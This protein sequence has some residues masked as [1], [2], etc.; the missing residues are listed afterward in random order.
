MSELTKPVIL[1]VDDEPTNLKF[2]MEILKEDY[3]V[4]L[5][6]SGERALVFL[7][8]R[9]PDI[10][11]LD[12]EMPKMNGYEVIQ[13][14]KES[15]DWADI[16]IIFLTGLEGRDKEQEAF[17]LGAV[18]YILKPISAGVVKARVK[19]HVEL[20]TYR[21]NLEAL[22]DIRTEQLN[23][24]QNCILNMLVSVTSYRDQETGG[25]IKRTTFYLAEITKLLLKETSDEYH[26]SQAY[27]DAM[28]I[29][30]KLHDIGKVA[31][32]DSILLKPGRL[33]PEEF[34]VIK[35]H[36]VYGAHLLD[37]AVSELEET[38]SFLTVARE[39]IIGHH[40]H[41]DGNG[42]PNKTKEHEI[43]LSARVMAIVDVYDALISRRPYKEPYSHDQA[44][45]TLRQGAGTHFDPYLIQLC[46][47]IFPMFQDIAK[48]HKD[49][50]MVDLLDLTE[51]RL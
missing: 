24:T 20:G 38:A 14:I 21:K 36:T 11:L 46:E 37:N 12:I 47:P 34:E 50:F 19:L 40:E 3:Q 9:R 33:T 27:A 10:I 28:V 30:T 29:S 5:A 2:L 45:D 31:V 51:Y 17:A 18:D 48:E 25:H 6:P 49:D 44:I 4:Y 39:I 43:P 1:C 13:R 32:P 16:P 35:L 23:R 8:T 22:V 41:W 42:Y 15:P 26:I 7:D